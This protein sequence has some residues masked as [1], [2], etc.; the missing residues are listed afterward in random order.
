MHLWRSSGSPRAPALPAKRANSRNV[1]RRAVAELNRRLDE[2]PAPTAITMTFLE[3]TPQAGS[4]VPV[5]NPALAPL[6]KRIQ[7]VETTGRRTGPAGS[8][9]QECG[10]VKE[11]GAH[12]TDDLSNPKLGEA[13]AGWVVGHPPCGPPANLC[14]APKRPLTHTETEGERRKRERGRERK[15]LFFFGEWFLPLSRKRKVRRR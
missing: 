7:R 11:T 12:S 8:A 9:R 3:T 1:R 5:A 6:T 13:T 14:R 4:N 15:I 2:V 10:C